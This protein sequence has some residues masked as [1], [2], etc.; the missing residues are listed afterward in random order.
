MPNTHTNQSC[1]MIYK[2]VQN[3]P[4]QK[5]LLQT[6]AIQLRIRMSSIQAAPLITSVHGQHADRTT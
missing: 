1:K 6:E 5:K 4:R 2:M 3:I